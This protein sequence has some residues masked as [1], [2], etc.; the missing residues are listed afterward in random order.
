MRAVSPFIREQLSSSWSKADENVR[1]IPAVAVFMRYLSANEKK[2]ASQNRLSSS[3]KCWNKKNP[4]DDINF[5]LFKKNIY[6]QLAIETSNCGS[7]RDVFY[8]CSTTSTSASNWSPV[9]DGGSERWWPTPA[10]GYSVLWATKLQ[11]RIRILSR[12]SA[13]QNERQDCWNW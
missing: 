10:S 1:T 8:L 9:K 13:H 12:P 7:S 2:I 5:N 6:Q 4:F 3:G 11:N